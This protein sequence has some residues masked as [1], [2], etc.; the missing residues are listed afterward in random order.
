EDH[1]KKDHKELKALIETRKLLKEA[2]EQ[3]EKAKTKSSGLLEIDF[4]Q[5]NLYINQE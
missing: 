4:S 2:K 5:N 3:Q 1:I